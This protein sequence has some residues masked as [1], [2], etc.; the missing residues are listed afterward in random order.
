[1]DSLHNSARS[2]TP[3]TGPSTRS[4][5]PS[6]ESESQL[7]RQSQ[8]DPEALAALPPDL[9]EEVLAQYKTSAGAEQAPRLQNASPHK[10]WSALPPKKTVT[11]TKK[12]K[13][14]TAF[15]KAR[16]RRKGDS[17]STLTQSNFV[18]V[19]RAVPEQDLPGAYASDVI[20]ES[21][22][23]ELPEDIRME[24]L[25]EQRRNRM[26]TKGNLDYE[27]SRKKSRQKLQEES[28]VRGQQRIIQLSKPADTPTF[29]SQKLSSLPEL[30]DA[31][32]A[33]V[34]EFASEGEGPAQEDVDALSE[35][36]SK[37]VC[38]ERDM[39][40][41][42]TIVNWLGLVVEYENFDSDGTR[43]SW[44]LALSTLKQ[45]VQAAVMS[46]GLPAVVF[47]C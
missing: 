41:A 13:T 28:A 12:Q 37:V 5:S 8:L 9:R 19:P 47:E 30:R 46:R 7:P 1:L 21:F 45:D 22:L 44:E 15:S 38:V 43:H 36:L 4:A 10:S 3:P 16:S 31:T 42:V 11:P 18:S 26:K 34:R 40:K 2:G 29:T 39:A 17:S 23:N 32:S 20:S 24:I 33:W 35:Y 6:S 27:S 25:A 14:T